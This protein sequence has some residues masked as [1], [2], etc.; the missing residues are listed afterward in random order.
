[1]IAIL[2]VALTLGVPSFKV[3]IQNTKIRT[4]AESISYGL[5]L[6]RSEAIHRNVAVRFSLTSAT[7]TGWS[8]ALD[9]TPL[10]F[11]HQR[12]ANEGSLGVTVTVTPATAVALTFSALGR[13]QA[14]MTGVGPSLTQIDVDSDTLTADESRNLRILIN[15]G[16]GSRL[17]DPE[18]AATDPRAC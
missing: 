10:V 9:S 3:W 2:G 7:S 12:S 6:A 16:G 11:L 5:S 18:L 15:A 13:K 8:V 4:A 14:N 17:C 1:M